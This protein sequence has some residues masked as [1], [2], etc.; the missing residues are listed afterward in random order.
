MDFRPVL[1][2]AENDGFRQG[3]VL[4]EE[5]DDA[6]GKLRVVNRQRLDLMKRHKNF[7]E[8]HFV[9]LFQGQGKSVNNAAENF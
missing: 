6:I 9:L 4:L 2:K 5:L 8:E 7:E 3:W 1:E